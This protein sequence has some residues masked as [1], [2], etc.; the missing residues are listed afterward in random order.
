MQL[1]NAILQHL[2]E[3]F[4]NVAFQQQITVDEIP[5]VWVPGE[6]IIPVIQYLKS[7]PVQAFTFLYDLSGIDER[8]KTK[9][10]GTPP[11]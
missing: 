4:S 11:S 10:T 7:D 8:N 1:A 6:K 9:K 2:Q 3:R 5:T